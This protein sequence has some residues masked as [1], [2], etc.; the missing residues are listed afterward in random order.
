MVKGLPNIHHPNELYKICVPSKLHL[1]IFENK[2][3]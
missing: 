1:N 2:A 3:N